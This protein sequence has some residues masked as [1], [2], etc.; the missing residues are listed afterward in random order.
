MVSYSELPFRL[1]VKLYCL[2]S[3]YCIQ[4]LE[5]MDASYAFLKCTTASSFFMKFKFIVE[6]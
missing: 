5:N 4:R 2:I 3:N 1:L 6:I